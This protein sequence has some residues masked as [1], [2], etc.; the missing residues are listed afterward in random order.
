MPELPEVETIRRGL[1]RSI[2]G[3]K[4]AKVQVRKPAM[5]RGS[6]Q[7]LVRA[8]R[9]AQFSK[10]GRRGKL[11]IFYIKGHDKY[12]L[13]HL[14]MT[15]QLIYRQGKKKLAGGHPWPPFGA[16]LPNKYSHITIDFADGSQLFFNDLR[17]FGYMQLVN[18]KILAPVLARYGPEPLQAGFSLQKFQQHFQARKT[19]LKVA[20]LDQQLV[21]GIGNIYA[22]EICFHARLLPQRS[23]PS[24]STQEIRAVHKAI[25]KVL[26]LAVKHRGTTFSD[27][28]DSTG[29]KGNFV[30]LLKVYGRAGLLCKRCSTPIQ[31]TKLAGRGTHYCPNCQK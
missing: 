21:A 29:K 9:A 10:I 4:I 3:K 30:R 6:A 2:V 12:L 24:L 28:R 16:S 14:K 7:S 25:P 18:A 19:I 8:I 5:I 13:V 1:A 22:D 20:L 26:G 23:I 31:K 15:G 27:Y 17:Q 11:L